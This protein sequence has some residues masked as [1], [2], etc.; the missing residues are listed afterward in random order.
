[1]KLIFAVLLAL[2]VAATEALDF[3]YVNIVTNERTAQR[4]AYLP[5]LDASGN[6]YWVIEKRQMWSPKKKLV[7]TWT[8]PSVNAAWL[9]RQ[10][11]GR[12]FYFNTL[13]KNLTTWEMPADSNLAWDAVANNEL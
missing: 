6:N 1:M 3:T 5:Y 10:L 9:K 11:D 8:P 2:F 13:D 4:P 7:S 12:T